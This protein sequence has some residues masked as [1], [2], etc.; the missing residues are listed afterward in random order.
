MSKL[1]RFGHVYQNLQS[2]VTRTLLHAFLDPTKS[3]SQ[4]YG[5][6]Q[7]LAALGPSVVF[8]IRYALFIC[9]IRK[10][11]FLLFWYGRWGNG[12]KCEPS[13]LGSCDIPA[14]KPVIPERL[15]LPISLQ[16]M[17]RK[18]GKEKCILGWLPVFWTCSY[19]FIFTWQ[20]HILQNSWEILIVLGFVLH[21]KHGVHLAISR[22]CS[23]IF[24]QF[25]SALQNS[26]SFSDFG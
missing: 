11:P 2:R 22:H 12:N 7:G 25:Y 20:S 4:H 13:V 3:L 14:T 9:E 18:K 23:F 1:C 21:L 26:L 16:D 15:F 10:Q 19:V 8:S 5:A 24:V 17:R 6:I